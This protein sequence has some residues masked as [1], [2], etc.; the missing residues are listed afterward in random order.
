[1]FWIIKTYAVLLLLY[2]ITAV[3]QSKLNNNIGIFF[4]ISRIVVYAIVVVFLVNLAKNLSNG[5]LKLIFAALFIFLIFSLLAF[6]DV[7]LN[8]ENSTFLGFQ[9]ICIGYVLENICFATAF[10]YKIISTDKQKKRTEIL[11]QKQLVIVEQE[12]QQQTMQYLGRE[13]HDNIGQKLILAS[14]GIQQLTLENIPQE[15]IK[16]IEDVNVTINS[17]LSELRLLSKSLTNNEIENKKII[18]LIEGESREINK[19]K[20]CTLHYNEDLRDL[21]LEYQTKIILLRIIQEFSQNSIKHAICS[22][23]TIDLK[24]DKNVLHLSLTDDGKGFNSKS[25]I[26]KGIGLKNMMKRISLI[27]GVFDLQSNVEIGTKLRIEIP[28]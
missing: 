12:M 25:P 24:V 11:H 23:I 1:M 27:G 3:V 7:T 20:K 5:N 19:I 26:V 8:Y 21:I 10:I 2:L 18:D 9:Y 17:A 13:I 4:E 16:K 14:I 6:Y 22:L 28:Y 15:M